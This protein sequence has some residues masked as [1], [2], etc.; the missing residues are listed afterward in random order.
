MAAAPNEIEKQRW[1]DI[2][3]TTL[4]PQREALTDSV[5]GDLLA[6]LAARP[7]ER[8]LDIG[9]GGG[10]AALA[11]G[12][13]VGPTGRVVGVDISRA[14]VALAQSRAAEAELP[15][16]GFA[17]ADAQEEPIPGAPFSAA[18]SQFGVMFFDEPVKAFSNV[19]RH[20]APEGRLVFACWQPMDQNPWALGHP[21]GSYAPPPPSP[22][23]GKSPTGPFA[24]GD[25]PRTVAW[26]EEAGWADV[27]VEAYER[28]V[29]VDRSAIFDDGQLA[30]NGV[31]AENLPAARDAV[32]RHLAQFARP[33]GRLDVPVAFLIVVATER[34]GG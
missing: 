33:D 14:L 7:G 2:Y 4:W 20:V 8:V 27:R 3:W 25:A 9:S 28:I 26:L 16:V 17:E 31:A 30:F 10:R 22:G 21:L 19:R 6:H 23:P 18:M 11:V 15:N 32:V 34:S 29:T 24:L 12:V 5:T 1:N 13:Q